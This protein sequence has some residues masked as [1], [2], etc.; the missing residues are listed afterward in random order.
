MISHRWFKPSHPDDE[1][2][3]L[4]AIQDYLNKNRHVRYV[5]FGAWRGGSSRGSLASLRAREIRR[6]PPLSRFVAHYI[7]ARQIACAPFP[8]ALCASDDH[9]VRAIDRSARGADFWCMPQGRGRTIREE[10]EFKHMLPNINVLYLTM[11]VLIL[12]DNSCTALPTESSACA[13][14][15]QHNAAPLCRLTAHA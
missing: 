12:L 1:G 3:Q 14:L 9:A 13:L 15:G 2:V 7:R 10:A 8:E 11:P 5:W 4:R 6:S